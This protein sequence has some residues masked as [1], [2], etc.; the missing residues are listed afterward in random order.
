MAYRYLHIVALFLVVTTLFFSGCTSV[1][2]ADTHNTTVAVQSYN[3]WADSQKTYAGNIR[4]SIDTIGQHIAG[5]NHELAQ[6]QPDVKVLRAGIASDKQLLRDWETQETSL[7]AATAKFDSETSALNFS[8]TPDAKQA[9]GVLSQDMK[10][11]SVSMKNAEQHLVDYTNSMN[12]YLAPDDP[13]YWN[14]DLRVAAMAANEEAVK[15]I[16]DGDQALTAVT[17]A[18]KKLEGYQ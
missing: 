11:Y 7:D 2:L 14:D 5:Y 10:I 12:A 3:A 8:A 1:R 15:S 16:A 4:S 13:D 6:G 18:G 17:S 9:V